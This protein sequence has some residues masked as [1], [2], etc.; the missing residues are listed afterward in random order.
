RGMD[1]CKYELTVSRYLT[2]ITIF[3][4]N[5]ISCAYCSIPGSASE[6]GGRAAAQ[7]TGGVVPAP[8]DALEVAGWL[9]PVSR[10]PGGVF[11]CRVQVGVGFGVQRCGVCCLL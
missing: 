6:P 8:V 2:A 4:A 1:W 7:R 5:K 3:I 9:E 11:Q 10:S